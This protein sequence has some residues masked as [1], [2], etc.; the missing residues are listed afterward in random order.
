M[1]RKLTAAQKCKAYAWVAYMTTHHPDE[2]VRV[3]KHGTPS[4]GVEKLRRGFP[5]SLKSRRGQQLLFDVLKRYDLH[6]KSIPQ[7]SFELLQHVKT[8]VKHRRADTQANLHLVAEALLHRSAFDYKQEIIFA[9]DSINTWLDAVY[10]KTLAYHTLR[11]CLEMLDEQGIITVVEWGKRG[12]RQAATR[13]RMNYVT[14]FGRKRP[15]GLDDWL[16]MSDHGMY[17]V[18]GRESTTRQDVLEATINW[19][20]DK[21]AEEARQAA[22]RGPYNKSETQQRWFGGPA[23]PVKPVKVQVLEEINDD[24]DVF[25]GKLVP[26]LQKDE[27]AG[28]LVGAGISRQGSTGQDRGRSA[29]ERDLTNMPWDQF[30]AE[31][32]D[33]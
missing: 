28:V 13:I 17:A 16:M 29:R 22:P 15:A 7:K 2:M 3:R 12:Y 24:V 5:L 8:T 26:A 33:S 21:M 31:L 20:S 11:R 4:E 23:K 9:F 32:L 27:P 6:C 25:L 19:F 10:K 18:H 30:I 14:H 1:S